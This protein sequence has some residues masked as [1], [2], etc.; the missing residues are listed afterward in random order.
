M[1]REDISLYGSEENKWDHNPL[2]H[3]LKWLK[4]PYY[5]EK[6]HYSD[7]PYPVASPA[8]TNVPLLGPLLAATIG[9]FIK[10]TVCIH[11]PH[12]RGRVERQGVR[13]LLTAHRTTRTRCPAVTGTQ[14]R[15]FPRQRAQA[16]SR[17]R[18][19]VHRHLRLRCRKLLGCLV[20]RYQRDGER[21]VLPGLTLLPN[22]KTPRADA[23]NPP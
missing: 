9:R 5:L 8:F 2:L 20:P 12:A 17:Y 23:G 7:R 6:L 13:P 22:P 4:D 14:G 11:G 16:G 18:Q 10:P 15:E 21:G 1:N 3:P 19:G